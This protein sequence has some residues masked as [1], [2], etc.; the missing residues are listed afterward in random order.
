W[1]S[2]LLRDI[3][4]LQVRAG[5]PAAASQTISEIDT[6]WG[7]VKAWCEVARAQAELADS[8]AAKDSFTAA[9]LAIE[10]IDDKRSRNEAVR[11]IAAAQVKAGQFVAATRTA[12]HLNEPWEQVNTLREIALAQAHAGKSLAAS[13]TLRDALP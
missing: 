2:P 6:A 1:D 7:K 3:A 12:R 10:G 5:Q 4:V 8:A 13:D 11:E 9:L